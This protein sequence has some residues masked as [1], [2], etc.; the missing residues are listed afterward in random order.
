M[1]PEVRQRQFERGREAAEA[2]ALS[3]IRPYKSQTEYAED[4]RLY[5]EMGFTNA[6]LVGDL[7]DFIQPRRAAFLKAKALGAACVDLD[8]T[9]AIVQGPAPWHPYASLEDFY[10]DRQLLV[11]CGFSAEATKDWAPSHLF[12]RMRPFRQ[13]YKKARTAAEKPEPAPAI[14]PQ[15]EPVPNPEPHFAVAPAID[16]SVLRELDMELSNQPPAPASQQ[17]EPG[18]ILPRLTGIFNLGSKS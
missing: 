2:L 17:P 18:G 1:P 9:S 6:I 4:K 16:F 8:T 12:D 10:H 14:E 13:A 7:Y 11:E 15:A 3:N 5:V